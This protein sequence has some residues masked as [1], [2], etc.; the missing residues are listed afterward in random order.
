MEGA[1]YTRSGPN[2]AL[3]VTAMSKATPLV[4]EP[5]VS[6]LHCIIYCSDCSFS[7]SLETLR[8]VSRE[9]QS[10]MRAQLVQR[11]LTK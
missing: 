2:P 7:Q 9:H 6:L 4:M 1:L 8:S 3:E 5:S 11:E 10:Q